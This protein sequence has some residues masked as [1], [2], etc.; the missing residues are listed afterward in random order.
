[1]LEGVFMKFPA[2]YCL[3]IR[4]FACALIML[5]STVA[6]AVPPQAVMAGEL[7]IASAWARATAPGVTVGAVYFTVENRGPH[8]DSLL[9][10]TSPISAG[11]QFHRTKQRDGVSRMGPAVTIDIAPGQTVKIEPGALHLMLTGLKQPLA[12]GRRIPMT[13][14]FRHAGTVTVQVEIMPL[15][16]QPLHAGPRSTIT[17]RTE[18]P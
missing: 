13:L 15:G 14:R 7:A 5:I 3:R 12:A 6:A 4:Q 2:T 10:A 11:T 1:L 16:T 8:L 18:L 9:S 17:T